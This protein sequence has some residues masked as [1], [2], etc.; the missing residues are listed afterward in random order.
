MKTKTIRQVVSIRATPREVYD[1]LMTSRGH[2]GFTG[3]PA[4]VTPRV[5]TTFTLWGGYIHGKNLELV[6][7]RR[8]VQAWRPSEETWPPT[9]YS[10]VRYLLRPTKTG[11]RIGFTHSGVPVD[12]AGHLSKG[13]KTSYWDPLRKYLEKPRS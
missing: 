5:G 3:A 6:A 4:R 11:T 13:W 12:H 2:R 8:I 9:H 10:K 7:G 1:A